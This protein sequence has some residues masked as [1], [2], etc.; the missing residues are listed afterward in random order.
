MFRKGIKMQ[1]HYE[2]SEYLQRSDE[3]F[4]V[5]KGRITSSNIWK[6]MGAPRS[7]KDVFSE[8]AFTYIRERVYELI[9]DDTVFLANQKAN[10]FENAATRWGNDN[11]SYARELYEKR[12]G[13]KVVESFFCPYS[14]RTGGSF[15]GEIQ[16]ENGLIEIKSPFNGSNHIEN[17]LMT[18]QKDL[19]K[20]SP[21][22]YWQCM[23]NILFAHAEYCDF[24][25]FDPRMSDL[26]RLKV[27]RILPDE[28]AINLLKERIELAEKLMTEM[29][30][31]I[32]SIAKEQK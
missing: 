19:L 9:M 6:I 5:R 15:D 24:T 10:G 31:E 13:L 4:L 25:S 18:S 8:T 16:S 2:M 1:I 3:W 12:T 28:E 29:L 30:S 20:N 27:L 7:K 21:A 14:K 32:I 22:Y 23:A 17:W 26:M 11:E